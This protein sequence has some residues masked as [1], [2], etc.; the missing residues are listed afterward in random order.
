MTE[1]RCHAQG[2]T[3]AV[4][5]RLLMCRRHWR[6]V[7]APLARAVWATYVPGQEIRKDPTITYLEAAQAAVAAV[8]E[9]ER[10]REDS[11]NG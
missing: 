2:C 1:H 10:S 9:K 3:V 7:P 4:P 11:D 6:M 5:P 8:A